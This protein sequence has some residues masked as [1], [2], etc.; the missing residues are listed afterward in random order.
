MYLSPIDFTQKVV[1]NPRMM[2]KGGAV[3]P[4]KY[5]RTRHNTPTSPGLLARMDFVAQNVRAT[6]RLNDK[7]LPRGMS[8]SAIGQPVPGQPGK[9]YIDCTDE[10]RVARLSRNLDCVKPIL[11]TKGGIYGSA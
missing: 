9:V 4:G 11:S 3:Y 7:C 1:Y 6:C 8:R 5:I 10:E 2:H